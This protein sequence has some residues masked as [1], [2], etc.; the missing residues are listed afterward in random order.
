MSIRMFVQTPLGLAIG[1]GM[2]ILALDPTEIVLA[3]PAAAPA[4][5]ASA[6]IAQP[7]VEL[8]LSADRQV[9]VREPNGQTKTTWQALGTQSAKVGQGDVI[10][11]T[12]NGQNNG[13]AAARNVVL[14]QA[15]PQGT[16][17]VLQSARLINNP[18]ELQF[19]ID[20]GK[21]FSPAPMVKVKTGTQVIEQ[22]APADAYTHIRLGIS[23]ELRPKGTVRGEYQ[24]TVK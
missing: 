3:T 17:Y 13:S 4:Q 16:R 1:L 15:I 12:L 11:F 7:K 18:G 20:G 9:V 24:V 23:Q 5:R 19:S 2:T 10:R 8:K 14:N 21:S 22:A 6:T